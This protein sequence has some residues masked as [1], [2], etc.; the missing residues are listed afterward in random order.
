[1]AK[2]RDLIKCNSNR[3]IEINSNEIYNEYKNLLMNAV[4]IKGL[5]YVNEV[6]VKNSLIESG[7]VG[8]DKL[9]NSWADVYGTGRNEL[10]NPTELVFVFKNGQTFTRKA[11]YAN[12]SLG[13]YMVNAFPNSFC[14]S[15]VIK[16]ASDFIANCN[17]AISQNI[18][19]CKTPY[20]VVCKNKDL[21][22]SV[23]QALQQKQNGQA[24]IV[25]SEDLGEGLRG[26]NIAT[27]YLADKFMEIRDQERDKLLNK[28]G[29]MSANTEKRERVQVGEVN[30]TLGQ[31]FDYI[32]LM[33]D[34]FN[35]Q[36]KNFGINCEMKLNSS[37]EEL[38][39]NKESEVSEN[40]RE[41]VSI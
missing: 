31:C 7:C 13:A 20:I 10:G 35:K 29:I 6:F 32:Y 1:M 33:I 37:L 4:E 26:V 36:M 11:S 34:T 24:A 9:T 30:A 8:Y 16:T 15:K 12:E 41:Q 2:L 17:S 40:E 38:Y 22:L 39:E 25:V 5:D 14:F 19:A 21:M 28:F 18:D 3:T 27:Q 23:E